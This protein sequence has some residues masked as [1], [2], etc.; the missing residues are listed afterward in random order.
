MQQS[1][2]IDDIL[3]GIP[4]LD[5]DGVRRLARAAQRHLLTPQIPVGTLEREA[6]E[7][8]GD[9]LADRVKG[10]R[11]RARSLMAARLAE[12]KELRADHTYKTAVNAATDAAVLSVHA[13][14][15]L[16]EA[17]ADNLAAAWV[18]ATADRRAGS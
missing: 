2:T 8:G 18:E 17:Q 5:R 12:Y 14:E 9:E 13:R 6:I 4:N 1:L 10:D 11:G 16:G 7:A 15:H 3:A